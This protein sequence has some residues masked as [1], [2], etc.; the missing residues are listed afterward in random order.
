MSAWIVS[1]EHIDALVTGLVRSGIAAPTG[2]SPDQLGQAL[3]AEN[4][5]SVNARYG[6]ED[7]APAYVHAV[8][9][10]P[11]AVLLKQVHCYDYQSCEHG[12]W[13]TSPANAWIT[14]LDGL[15]S[16]VTSDTSPAYRDAPWGI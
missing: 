10:L 8:L 6:E 11:P 14:T 1:K 16:R 3:W 13:E 7:S 12:G 5:A 9:D 4:H 2:L 15:L